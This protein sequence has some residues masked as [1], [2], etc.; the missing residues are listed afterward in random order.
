MREQA[1]AGKLL[2]AEVDFSVA[3]AGFGQILRGGKYTGDWNYD[4]VIEMAQ[5]N[6]G[7][8]PYGY[9]T[10]FVQLVRK[11]KTAKGM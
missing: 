11:A 7:D 5:K 6:K 3:V 1:S 10:E 8:D 2:Q 4:D 9:R